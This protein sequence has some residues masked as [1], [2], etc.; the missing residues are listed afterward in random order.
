NALSHCTMEI[1]Q[2]GN[3]EPVF[4]QTGAGNEVAVT[5]TAK[6]EAWQSNTSASASKLSASTHK[7]GPNV[8][9]KVMAGDELSATT[10]YYYKDP[11][12]N[13]TG[14]NLSATIITSLIQSILGSPAAGLAKTNT[15]GIAN[16]LN[17]NTE[18]LNKTAP[19][20]NNPNGNKPKAYLTVVFFNERFEFVEEGSTALRVAQSGDN[21]PELVLPNIK[22]P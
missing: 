1:P 5:R 22:A 21:A 20:A 6:P 16:Q 4:G 17:A 12:T 3:E 2:A 19:D 15:T 14:N 18:F 7:A 13:S 11:V 9:L 8:L 10:N